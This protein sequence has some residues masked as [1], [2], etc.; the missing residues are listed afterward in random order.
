[1]PDTLKG[2]LLMW[3]PFSK[4]KKK[5]ANVDSLIESLK[6]TISSWMMV[7]PQFPGYSTDEFMFNWKKVASM[8]D[9]F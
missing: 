4:N 5:A 2:K 3:T 8:H 1:M 7:L 6:F 9:G